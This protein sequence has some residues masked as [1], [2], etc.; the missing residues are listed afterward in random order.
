MDFY[1][2]RAAALSPG[3]PDYALLLASPDSRFGDAPICGTCGSPVAMRPWLSPYEVEIHHRGDR[4]PDIA[5]IES[6]DDILL[7]EAVFTALAERHMSGIEGGDPVRFVSTFP[8]LHEQ[9]L[10]TYV[11]VEARRTRTS[12]DYSASR[13]VWASPPTCD[14]CRAGIVS[15]WD[16]LAVD[17][18]T[19]TGEDLFVTHG[20]PGVLLASERLRVLFQ[21]LS[22]GGV[23]FV[24]L[25]RFASLFR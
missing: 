20:S 4:F 7:T 12:L 24:P 10:P 13:I 18:Q 17:V 6:G 2:L 21:S 22:I 9:N 5:L 25:S 1:G 11:H 15:S 16:S 19:W 8:R 3:M 14:D 23:D